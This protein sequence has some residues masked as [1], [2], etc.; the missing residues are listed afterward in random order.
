[1]AAYNI[2]GRADDV[3]YAEAERL[4]DLLLAF[5]PECTVV[6][7]RKHPDHWPGFAKRIEESLGCVRGVWLVAP[8][9]CMCFEDICGCVRKREVRTGGVT[10][11]H[12]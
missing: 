7:F 12:G 10:A 4:C 9:L 1:M 2:A 6:K 11:S 3:D 5:L 8:V